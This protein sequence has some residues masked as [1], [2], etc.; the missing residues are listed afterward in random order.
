M[1][2]RGPHEAWPLRIL[3][4]RQ[5]VVECDQS[6]P[7][8]ML[9]HT[10]CYLDRW[11]FGHASTHT[12]AI[13]TYPNNPKAASNTKSSPTPKTPTTAASHIRC[14]REPPREAR[15]SPPANLAV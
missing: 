7:T 9:L 10:F 8:C 6:L 1:T 14:L 15:A 12:T 3:T 13:A 5:I 11:T 2:T 4:R